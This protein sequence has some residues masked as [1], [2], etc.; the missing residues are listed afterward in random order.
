MSKQSKRDPNSEKKSDYK[1][2]CT[3]TEQ[4]DGW[5][6]S[7]PLSAFVSTPRGRS[8]ARRSACTRIR[9]RIRRFNHENTHTHTWARTDKHR[10]PLYLNRSSR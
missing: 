5:R 10:A 1:N 7:S 8:V 4:W 2:G 9:R 6:Q 3:R